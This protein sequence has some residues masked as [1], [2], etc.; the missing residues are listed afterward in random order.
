VAGGLG[1][2][3]EKE[4][5][6]LF[7]VLLPGSEVESQIGWQA[8]VL[9][10]A[11]VFLIGWVFNALAGHALKGKRRRRRSHSVYKK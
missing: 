1:G 6:S 8:F 7:S 2:G 10:M 4:I 5:V 11:G 3:E 9:C